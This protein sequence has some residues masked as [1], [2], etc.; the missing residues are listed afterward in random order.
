MLL[1]Q[2]CLQAGQLSFSVTHPVPVAT[3]YNEGWKIT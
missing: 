3:K 1:N 2:G